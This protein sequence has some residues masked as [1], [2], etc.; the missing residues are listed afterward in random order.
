MT[1]ASNS[2]E[3]EINWERITK[4]CDT[5]EGITLRDL[6]DSAIFGPWIMSAICNGINHSEYLEEEPSA[7]DQLLEYKIY[8]FTRGIPYSV[9]RAMFAETAE[10]AKIN[11]EARH[12]QGRN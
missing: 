6:L 11:K 7:E 12:S 4:L 3:L 1:S 10:L 8:Q 5:C 9:R 2:S